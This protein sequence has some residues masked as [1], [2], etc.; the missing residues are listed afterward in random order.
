MN[1]QGFSFHRIS[2]KFQSLLI[3]IYLQRFRSIPKSVRMFCCLWREIPYDFNGLLSHLKWSPLK[4]T[5]LLIM[6]TGVRMVRL[7]SKKI[8]SKYVEMYTKCFKGSGPGCCPAGLSVPGKTPKQPGG[9]AGVWEAGAL[10]P[11][12][13]TPNLLLAS[14]RA[15]PL[16]GGCSVAP[17]WVQFPRGVAGVGSHGGGPSAS[18]RRPGTSRGGRRPSSPPPG[19]TPKLLSAPPLNPAPGV[20][21]GLILSPPQDPR[22]KPQS[23]PK[24][25]TLEGKGSGQEARAQDLGSHPRGRREPSELLVA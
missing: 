1:Y 4:F 21:R 2:I 13:K 12:L 9:V 17:G 3:S 6:F 7:N 5:G 14:S 19:G 11:I 15:P 18:V 20:F 16:P 10:G 24:R 22:S 25:K 8:P 23:R